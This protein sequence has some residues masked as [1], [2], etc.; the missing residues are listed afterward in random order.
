MCSVTQSCPT[1]CHPMNCIAC[2]APLSM[3]FS[4]QE[5][6]IRLPFDLP[7]AGIEPESLS[8]PALVGGFFSTSATWEAYFHFPLNRVMN[9][10]KW[11]Q[12]GRWR[13]PLS[14]RFFLLL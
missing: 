5:Y 11:G 4:K 9:V 10:L 7:D 8:S 1:L 14:G 3:E 12:R 6:W 13:Q 2:Q